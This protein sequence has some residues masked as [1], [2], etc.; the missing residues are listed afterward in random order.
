VVRHTKKIVE[1][2]G[3]IF[4]TRNNQVL[5]D[6]FEKTADLREATKSAWQEFMRAVLTKKSS[7]ERPRA[8]PSVRRALEEAGMWPAPADGG[9]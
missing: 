8:H 6:L 7:L 3:K 1:M 5:L 4:P 2:M 9:I